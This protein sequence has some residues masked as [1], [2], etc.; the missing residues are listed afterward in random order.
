[1]MIKT[2][3]GIDVVHPIIKETERAL[4][5]V[6]I[7]FWK[8]ISGQKVEYMKFISGLATCDAGAGLSR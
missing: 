6:V 3:A 7:Q 5:P 4:C 2:I 8:S 1:M